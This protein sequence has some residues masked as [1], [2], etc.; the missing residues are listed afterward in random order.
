MPLQNRVNPLGE[1]H[2]VSARGRFMGNRGC[3]HNAEQQVVRQW[4][5]LPWITCALSFKDYKRPK[6]MMPNSYTEL[7]FLDEPTAYAAGHNHA[8][9]AGAETTRCLSRLGLRHSRS[10]RICRPRL[11][12]TCCTPPAATMTVVSAPG[13][14]GSTPCRTEA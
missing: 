12:T 4:R 13:P 11:S 9:T 10:N 8:H 1:I 6:L 3:L 14:P 7:F 5:E 2:A